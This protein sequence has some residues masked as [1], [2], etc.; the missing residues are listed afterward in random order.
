MIQEY[1][2]T[3]ASQERDQAYGKTLE[4]VNEHTLMERQFP[5]SSSSSEVEEI[6]NIMWALAL[7]QT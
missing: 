2:E 6:N 1:Q 7:K 5:S 3:L 4:K